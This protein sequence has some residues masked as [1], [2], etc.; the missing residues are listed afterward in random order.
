M[1]IWLA[2]ISFAL[3]QLWKVPG[4]ALLAVSVIAAVWPAQRTASVDPMAAL[5]MD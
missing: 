1:R 3:R 4:F 5:R 2:G